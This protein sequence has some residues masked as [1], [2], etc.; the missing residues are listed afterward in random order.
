MA[1]DGVFVMENLNACESMVPLILRY[2]EGTLAGGERTRL[3]AHAVSCAG[4]RTA[5]AEQS[6]VVQLLHE[7]PFADPP[8]D[9]AARVRDRVAPRGG[10]LDLL[11][12]QAW[13]LRLAP[14]A[15]LIALVAWLPAQTPSAPSTPST[16]EQTA[17]AGDFETWAESTG[18]STSALLVSADAD[19]A[20]LLA[21]AYPGY[22]Q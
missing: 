16:V 9:F 21:A 15:A 17:S 18:D 20:E 8:R 11:N 5:I 22:A 3:E 2:A 14:V 10:L 1:D 7:V 19:P 13:T 4:C 12:W 6:A